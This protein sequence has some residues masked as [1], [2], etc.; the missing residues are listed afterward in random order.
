MAGANGGEVRARLTL[1]NSQFKKNMNDSRSQMSS[2]DKQ[3]QNNQK[4]FAQMQKAAKIAGV[5]VAAMG[6]AAVTTA[7]RFEQGMARVKALTGA[8]G[9]EFDMLETA[10]REAGATTVFSATDASEALSFLAMA[11]F[12][13]NDSVAAL[14]NVLNL[15]AA[16][17]VNLG[18]SADIVTNIMTGFGLT[19]EDTDHAVDVLVETMTSANTSLPQLGDAMKM[20]APVAEGL[21]WSMEDT[22]TAVAKMS[23]AGIQGQRAG[24]ALRAMLLSLANPTGQTADAMEELGIN[25]LDANDNMLPLPELVAEVSNKF[26]G[27]SD[28]QRTA[29]AQM[30]VGREAASGFLAIM[31]NSPEDLQEYITGLENS[32]GAAQRLS[33]IQNDTLIGSMKEFMSI[34]E[35]VG[36]SVGKELIPA[37][38]N[39]VDYGTNI[40]KT[41]SKLNPEIV[42]MG[43]K[44]AGG[45]SAALLTVG[46]INKLRTAMKALQLMSGPLGWISLAAGLLGGVAMASMEATEEVEEFTEVN[47]DQANALAD[48]SDNLGGMIDKYDKLRDSSKLTN[49]EFGRYM[50]ISAELDFETDA[51]KVKKLKDEQAGLAEK[52]GMSNE[53]LGEMV[54]LNGDILDIA[55]QTAEAITKNGDAMIGNADAAKAYNEELREQLRLELEKQR[56]NAI[57]N[58]KE[59]YD[60]L[61]RA[62][63]EQKRLGEQIYE[64]DKE[65]YYAKEE[66]AAA[67]QLA[68]DMIN[69]K[70]DATKDE[71]SE[72]LELVKEKGK[73]VDTIETAKESLNGQLHEQ[74]E[75]VNEQ[76]LGVMEG[77]KAVDKLVDF[78]LKQIEVTAEKGKE[79]EA[80]DKAIKK[81]EEQKKKIM[82]SKGENEKLTEEEREKI[83]EIETSIGKYKSV[84]GEIIGLQG[85]QKEF[86][87]TI[88]GSTS[89]VQNLN[90]EADKDHDKTITAHGWLITDALELSIEAAKDVDKQVSVSEIGLSDI[91]RRADKDESKLIN[92]RQSGLDAINRDAR[93]Q[94]TKNILLNP[95]GNMLNIAGK[96]HSGGTLHQLP[97][98][99]DG[100]NIEKPRDQEIESA[101]LNSIIPPKHDE[102][103]VRLLRNEMVLTQA[104]QASLF[105]MI[106]TNG[107]SKRNRQDDEPSSRGGGDSVINVDRLV[108]REEADVRRVAEELDQL[109]R[110]RNRN[111]GGR[112]R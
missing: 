28:T 83:S 59:G 47:L 16:A 79:I 85:D 49:D 100:G 42:A 25:I 27:M 45:A 41:I 24:T 64:K 20:V 92:M 44:F 56:S 32:E 26:E 71:I 80:I 84:K 77:Q 33:D 63:K 107:H 14:P 53:K 78:H 35:E 75:I 1:D 39:F 29:A 70:V 62:L 101:S 67:D 48:Q 61:T 50:D 43:L 82:E 3:A 40:V 11:G 102:V 6:A 106:E 94:V 51:D 109:K 91:V 81:Q 13:A 18:Q 86:T 110:Q 2:L 96:R 111:L 12:D 65:L 23:D 54:D 74:S 93:A 60:E 68:L 105:R 36:I 88:E 76:R 21:G 46:A 15:A 55:P 104:Q 8:T 4:G 66:H 99:H 90:Y 69:G 9:A 31:K 58:L 95:I 30:L 73:E 103:D 112:G 97:K 17:Q 87:S 34:V 108:V 72:Q 38:R 19:A 89:E 5:A 37:L 57:E 52:S 10:A 7:A 98:Y 22:A